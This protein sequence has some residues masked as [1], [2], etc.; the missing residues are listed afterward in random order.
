MLYP[1]E[2]RRPR[3]ARSVTAQ[4][5]TGKLHVLALGKQVV[6]LPCSCGQSSESGYDHRASPAAC[7]R[8]YQ[9]GNHGGQSQ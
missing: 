6:S 2:L 4:E 7:R 9:R 1:V 3:S 8:D 5:K